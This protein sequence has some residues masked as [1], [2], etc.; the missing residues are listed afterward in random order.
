MLEQQHVID[1]ALLQGKGTKAVRTYM[2]LGVPERWRSQTLD[3]SNG[4]R[5][6]QQESKLRMCGFKSGH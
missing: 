3:L 5:H 1:L 4:A 2:R 6:G